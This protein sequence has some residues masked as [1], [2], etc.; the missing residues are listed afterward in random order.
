MVDELQ[1][2]DNEI[3][4][5]QKRVK[6]IFFTTVGAYILWFGVIHTTPISVRAGD[7]GTFGDFIGGVLN[8]L[9]AYTAFV[10]LAKTY[11]L[12]KA[13]LVTTS[14]ALAESAKA[15][16]MQVELAHKSTRIAG[17]NTLISSIIAEIHI[18]RLQLQFIAE[19][20][21]TRPSAGGV[22]TLDGKWLK[23]QEIDELLDGINS[24]IEKR[25]S[26]RFGYEEELKVLL[27]LYKRV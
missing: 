15:Q 23:Q 20:L 8:P 25:L 11:R 24:Q 4:A 21:A 12:Q 14:Q 3:E 16:G 13:E 17:L 1:Q 19:Q 9:M 22:R 2:T 7:W 5:A 10:W 27:G 18:Q 26:E 6:Y